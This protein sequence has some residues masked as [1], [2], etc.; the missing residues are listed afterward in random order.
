[1]NNNVACRVGLAVLEAL[2]SG[3]L[4][5]EAA[6][7][8]ERLLARLE[9]MAE[10]HP[11]VVAAVRGK[12][13]MSAIELRSLDERGAFLSFLTHQGLYPYAVAATIAELA[14]VLVLPTLGA[15]NVLRV[16]PPLVISDGDLETALDGIESVV[17]ALDRH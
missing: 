2:T 14:S 8:G 6:R 3:D 4:C 10:R 17:A 7:K 1:A 15:A 13:L 12:G 9:R 11:A 5:A 16:S